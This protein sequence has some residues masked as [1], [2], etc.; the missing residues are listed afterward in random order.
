MPF[1]LFFLVTLLLSITIPTFRQYNTYPSTVDQCNLA[2]AF[3][4]SNMFCE[5]E[6]VRGHVEFMSEKVGNR[7]IG[8]PELRQVHDYLLKVIRDTMK[9]SSENGDQKK[10]PL[11]GHVKVSLQ[12]Q[13]ATGSF[14]LDK[15]IGKDL[16]NMYD[17]ITN[18]VVR[19]DPIS[20]DSGSKRALRRSPE[21]LF[22]EMP[23]IYTNKW[24]NHTEENRNAILINAHYDSAIGSPGATDDAVPVAVMLALLESLVTTPTKIK[25]PII[26]LFN[27]GE[28]LG[29]HAAHGFISQ[30]EWSKDVQTIINLESCG[31]GEGRPMLFQAGPGHGYVVESIEKTNPYPQAS[32]IAQDL[33]KFLPADTDYRVFT[34]HLNYHAAGV[35][36]AYTRNGYVYHTSRDALDQIRPGAIQHMGETVFNLVY[37]LTENHLAADKIGS[38]KKKHEPL[39]VD[40]LGLRLVVWQHAHQA[41]AILGYLILLCVVYSARWVLPS[42]LQKNNSALFHGAL[43]FHLVG[44]FVSFVT[45]FVAALLTAFAMIHAE[46]TMTWYTQNWIG[47]ALYGS[48]FVGIFLIINSVANSMVRSTVKPL[49]EATGRG[50]YE[51]AEEA[52]FW[53]LE[54]FLGIVTVALYFLGL[55]TSV[56]SFLFMVLLPVPFV[57]SLVFPSVSLT[58]KAILGIAPLTA[59]QFYSTLL[60]SDAAWPFFARMGNLVNAEYACAAV[61]TCFTFFNLVPLLPY[62]Q[63]VRKYHLISLL[64]FGVTGV[65]I[66]F[67]VHTPSAFNADRPRRFAVNHVRY[68]NSE[69]GVIDKSYI[70]VGAVDSHPLKASLN[71]LYDTPQHITWQ[72]L[73]RVDELRDFSSAYPLN[74]FVTGAKISLANETETG[75]VSPVRFDVRVIKDDLTD[76]GSFTWQRSIKVKINTNTAQ[77]GFFTMLKITSPFL[78]AWSLDGDIRR[79][80]EDNDSIFVRLVGEGQYEFSMHLQRVVLG[81]TSE[82]EIRNQMRV[83]MN[84]DST[85]SK[86]D[87]DL[88]LLHALFVDKG[89]HV[90]ELV[91]QQYNTQ[92][93]L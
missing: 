3:P 70:A 43:F 51:L 34:K 2:S 10:L 14:F 46:H 32:V 87:D 92:W 35:D 8:S 12:E 91:M 79:D 64:A 47:F 16:M 67:A 62:L 48:L 20:E 93:V 74:N 28:E 50:V 85:L 40:V 44:V 57:T 75:R 30:H 29:M 7:M 39:F 56:V 26:L 1:A 27:G 73:S 23:P 13:F 71:V 9:R 11:N 65:A 5:S 81:E 66:A 83:S 15:F 55:R 90:S 31:G 89:V 25:S 60:M 54:I 52:Q 6:K 69:T 33:I 84:M 58:L 76:V 19:V 59:Y 78:K 41:N 88:E 17:N 42:I 24:I 49:A 18:I 21:E 53:A 38:L 68:V 82:S 80:E 61:C 72:R 37:D 77:Q 86:R 45:G 4:A 22:E 63:N 36:L